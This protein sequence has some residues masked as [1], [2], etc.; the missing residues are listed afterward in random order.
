MDMI[1]FLG[2]LGLGLATN[3][4]YDLIISFSKKEIAKDY[5]TS[6]IQNKI[7]LHGVKMNADTVITAL[8]K[9]GFIS[10]Q[11]THLHANE[12]LVFGSIVGGASVGY[13]SKLTT[14][15][16]AI[17]ANGNASMNTVGNAQISQNDDGSISFH[18]GENGNINFKT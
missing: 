11:G 14:D 13:D 17:E 12:S 7:N 6:E 5:L 8:A 2:Q 10:I 4:I 15:K 16:T 3:S 18:V 9:N 1:A